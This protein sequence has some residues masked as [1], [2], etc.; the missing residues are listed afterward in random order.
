MPIIS[1]AKQSSLTSPTGLAT[2]CRPKSWY[3]Y[4]PHHLAHLMCGY[5]LAGAQDTAF[6]ISDGRAERFSSIMGE[7]RGGQV[8]V[9]EEAA[10]ETGDSI[11][12]LF[13]AITRHLG[14][15][16]NNDEYKVMGLSAFGEPPS[17]N[18]L[19]EYFVTLRENGRYT[20]SGEGGIWVMLKQL[21]RYFGPA[22]EDLEYQARLAAA[23]QQVV[24]IATAH[25]IRALEAKTNL[26]RLVFEGGLA[27]N[28]V[29]NT[30]LLEGSRFDD[31]A[32]S[33]AA[34]DPGVTVGA[35][36]YA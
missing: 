8:H 10:I 12:R 19:L 21:E 4:H 2:G 32:V 5:H 28:C 15:V 26:T 25:Q 22:R 1:V 6:L 17:P 34:S 23:A 35:A 33:F 31:M 36:V 7:V 18:P 11:A 16:P 24:E 3:W 14:F 13:S 20:V 29:N 27:L 9:F 30:K